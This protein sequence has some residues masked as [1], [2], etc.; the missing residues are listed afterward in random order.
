MKDEERLKIRIA[1]LRSQPSLEE[2]EQQMNDIVLQITEAATAIVPTMSW[3]T[4][5]N[6]ER[7]QGTCGQEYRD[8]GGLTVFL[9][10][11]GADQ[12]IPEKS[13]PQV[14]QSARE[15]AR[16]AGITEIQVFADAPGNRDVRLY[17][18]NGNAIMIGYLTASVISAR[19]GCRLPAADLAHPPS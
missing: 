3:A 4:N 10:Q 13:W 9:P 16:Q 11:M 19:T 2:T 5:N 7:S 8:T 14:L 6:R 18:E 1:E 12:A 17:G 15:I